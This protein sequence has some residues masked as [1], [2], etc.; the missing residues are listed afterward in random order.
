MSEKY[1]KS[2]WP[3]DFDERVIK[4]RSEGSHWHVVAASFGVDMATLRNR[5]RERGLF[6]PRVNRRFTP[7]DDA[8]LR[9]AY[10]GQRDLKEVAA[11]IGC[12]YGVLRQR[13]F[14]RHKDLVNGVRTPHGTKYLK[15]YGAQ[16]MEHGATP[17]EA[18]AALAKKITVAKAAARVHAIA[19]KEKRANDLI[20]TM[21]E[22]IAAGKPRN[23]AIFE[24]RALGLS[25]ERIGL[26]FD[27][28]RERIRQVCDAE[29]MRITLEASQEPPPFQRDILRVAS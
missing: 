6:V 14:H 28:T 1:Q 7:E 27:V 18:A 25:L 26:A 10:V 15:R 13:I 8:K 23:A 22:A 24:A 2:R 5:A 19:A 17:S 3:D 12:S 11:D 29:A 20:D 21:Q 4:M 16:L 9:A